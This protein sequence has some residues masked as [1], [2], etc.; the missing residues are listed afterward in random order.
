MSTAVVKIDPAAPGA[1]VLP[2]PSAALA[3]LRETPN[4]FFAAEE[5]F[6]ASISNEH[7]R[8]AYGRT[9]GRFL[10]WC[11]GRKLDLRD[12]TPG[13]AGDYM[14]QL[15]GSEPT[16]NQAL[17]AMRRFFDALVQRHAVALNPFA[18]VRGIKYS[19]TDGKTAELTIEQARKLFK[20][21]KTGNIVGL[22]DRAVLGVLA[23]TGA[24]VGAV[25]RLRLRDYRN[26]GEHRVLR[27]KEKNGKDREIPVRHDD[28]AVWIDEYIAAGRNRRG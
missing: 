5:F 10:T 11:A 12:V 15:P 22:R 20:S 21:I 24:R 18:S 6:K 16:K 19:V 9:V 4:A 23:Y 28:L 26:L 2:M 25:A 3:V 8:R 7:T 27:F 13:L 14:S 1:P 17:A